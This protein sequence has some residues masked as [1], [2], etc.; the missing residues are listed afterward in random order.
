MKL[1]G[2]LCEMPAAWW[3]PARSPPPGIGDSVADITPDLAEQFGLKA[4]PGVELTDV[5]SG[6]AASD[7]GLR[8]GDVIVEV[9]RQPVHNVRDYQRALGRAHNRL[10]L[11]VGRH[12]QKLF[13]A[14]RR[15]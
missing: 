5:A 4:R 1:L 7:A 13:I 9:D 10:L 3:S 6:S 2:K 11:L 15:S 12:G 14:L 8:P